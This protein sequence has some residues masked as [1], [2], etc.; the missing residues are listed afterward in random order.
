MQQAYLSFHNLSNF[1]GAGIASPQSPS[2]LTPPV[3]SLKLHPKFKSTGHQQSLSNTQDTKFQ[4]GFEGALL[5]QCCNK[6]WCNYDGAIKAAL[7]LFFPSL[8]FS[9]LSSNFWAPV[10][11]NVLQS[12]APPCPPLAASK[13]A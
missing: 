7:T 13:G 3:F 2:S 5:S 12:D 6:Q 1:L 9:P 4:K 11:P 8:I 10:T